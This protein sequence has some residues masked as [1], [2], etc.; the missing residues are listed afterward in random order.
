MNEP[1]IR[2]ESGNM[3][4]A[5]LDCET[6]GS[7]L[8]A[9]SRLIQAG[10]AVQHN[11]QVEIF[12]SL[13]GWTLDSWDNTTWSP[14]AEEVHGIT[15]DQLADAPDAAVVD[16]LAE[17]WLLARGVRPGHRNVLSVGFNVGSFDH[18]FFA[19]YLP[20]TY[21][22]VTHR[23]IDLNSVCFTLDGLSHAGVPRSWQ[24]WKDLAKRRAEEQLTH[25]TTSA[26]DAGYDAAE[27]LLGWLWL[28]EQV[29]AG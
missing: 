13:V 2:T 28:R 27:A 29:H 21:A 9:G 26:H 6:S 7:N 1:N 20:R 16:R 23:H 17:A 3:I 25:L 11:G 24:E 15:R 8:A 4:I 10:L 12:S 19:R 22:L 14:Q 5:G 18:P